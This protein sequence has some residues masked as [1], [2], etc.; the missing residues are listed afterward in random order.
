MK[1]NII[2]IL[3]V[4]LSFSLKAQRNEM[5]IMLGTTYYLGDLNPSKHFFLTKPAGGLV[6]RYIISQRWAFKMD[7]IIGSL[8]GNDAKAK[9][10]E[11]RNLSFR[12]PLFEASAQLE[13]NF[14][15]YM[16]GNNKKDYFTPYIFAGASVFSFNPKAQYDGTWY[17]LQPLGTEGQG[18]SLTSQ[19][20]YSLTT[21]SFPFGLGIKYSVGKTVCIGAEWGLRK[22]TTDYIDDVSTTYADPV[23]LGAE[24]GQ[25]AAILSDRT[26]EGTGQAVDNTGL[27][28]G[29]SGTK[30]WYSFAAFFITFKFK[31]KN[32]NSCP[33]YQK[34]YKFKDYFKKD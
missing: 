12:S 34:H 28:R 32:D 21:V 10:N 23:V 19:Q 29:N 1:K 14:L 30:D 7:G 24:H 5:G 26:N 25:I 11:A 22:T 6:Y 8:E 4:L 31:L 18:T 20:P 33:V 3:T 17:N 2:I 15:P 9:F 27:Q 16:T 13:L